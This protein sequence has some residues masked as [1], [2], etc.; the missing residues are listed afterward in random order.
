MQDIELFM[1]DPHKDWS[2]V[3]DNISTPKD[4][5]LTRNN[6]VLPSK[7]YDEGKLARS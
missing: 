2:V 3:N 6:V 4:M 5:L 1:P 7:C